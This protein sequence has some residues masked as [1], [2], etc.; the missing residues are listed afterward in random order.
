MFDWFR[1]ITYELGGIDSNA[2]KVERAAKKEQKKINRF[3]FSKTSKTVIIMMGSL[4]IIMAMSFIFS[5]GMAVKNILMTGVYIVMSMTAVT[6]ILALVF[7]KKKGEI[8][9]LTGMFVFAL[10]LF[11]SVMLM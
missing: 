7:G 11:G 1:D 4:Y 8:I 2:A 9:A 10:E 3:I 6:V 5:K